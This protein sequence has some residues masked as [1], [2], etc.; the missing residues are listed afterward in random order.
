MHRLFGSHRGI[1]ESLGGGGRPARWI[2]TICYGCPKSYSAGFFRLSPGAKRRVK[3]RPQQW[4]LEGRESPGPIRKMSAG[5]RTSFQ[6][7]PGGANRP[8][9][10]SKSWSKLSMDAT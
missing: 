3:G 1:G 9:T 4:G 10:Q 7:L 5:A 8:F 2:Y 6:E